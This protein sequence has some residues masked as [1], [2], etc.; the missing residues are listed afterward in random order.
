MKFSTVLK[1]FTV[2]IK[3]SIFSIGFLLN[4]CKYVQKHQAHSNGIAIKLTHKLVFYIKHHSFLLLLKTRLQLS[5]GHLC[6][7]TMVIPLH[8][9]QFH[10]TA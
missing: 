4:L 7:V 1:K 6:I 10:L 2:F 8:Y 5:L 3:F 9:P